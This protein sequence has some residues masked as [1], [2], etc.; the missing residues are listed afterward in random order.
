MQKS[1][2]KLKYKP[3]NEE[4]SLKN[5]TQ[6]VMNDGDDGLKKIKSPTQAS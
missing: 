3:L 1:D 5:H 4:I 6:L 2:K